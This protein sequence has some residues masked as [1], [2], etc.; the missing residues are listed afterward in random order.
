MY[1]ILIE[2]PTL[3]RLYV[4][5]NKT[6]KQIGEELKCSP[7]TVMNYMNRYGIK[8]RERYKGM[9]GKHQSDR[10]KEISSRTHK[11]KNVSAETRKKLSEAHK[12]HK[13]GHKKRR[14]DGY[15]Y[16]YYP[17]HPCATK[18]GYIMEHRYIMEKHIGRMLENDETVHH[19]N[20]V[21]DDNRIENLQLMTFKEHA[22]LHMRERW[23]TKKRGNDL[24][25]KH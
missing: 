12:M 5:E 3:E 25:I 17:D 2:K 18:D 14:T 19:I 7:V 22:G 8:S 15:T 24:S 11:G 16:L 10:V 21:R 4:D 23:E 1:K 9:L 13:V 6:M 20:H